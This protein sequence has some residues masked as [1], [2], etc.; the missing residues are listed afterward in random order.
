MNP[1]PEVPEDGLVVWMSFEDP[2]ADSGLSPDLSDSGF[3]GTCEIG[4]CPGVV[5]GPVGMAASFDGL[6]DRIDISD[7]PELR[8]ETGMSVSL[9]AT[10]T[11]TAVTSIVFGKAF[12]DEDRNSYEFYLSGDR[13][14]TLRWSMDAL[15]GQEG[16]A[17]TEY[18][19]SVRG[20]WVHLVG[21]WDSDALVLYVDGVQVATR[22]GVSNVYDAS[23]VTIGGDLNGLEEVHFWAGSVD[24]LRIYDRPLT[25]IEVTLLYEEG[26]D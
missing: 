19:F 2:T 4:R 12:E 9:W 20:A 15:A 23:P 13:T 6:N 8:F 7:R 3:H 10:Y 16:A 22:I 24:E 17:A 26:I 25:P 21:T 14:Q 18:P 11:G 1:V 5:P